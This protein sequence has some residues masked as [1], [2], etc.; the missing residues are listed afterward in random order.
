[1]AAH[2]DRDEAEPEPPDADPAEKPLDPGPPLVVETRRRLISA[3]AQGVTAH[4]GVH[5]V[6]DT[7]V[8]VIECRTGQVRRYYSITDE[9]ARGLRDDLDVALSEWQRITDELS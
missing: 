1:M 7:P 8:I 6:D 3:I 4:A 5:G 9:Q 2:D